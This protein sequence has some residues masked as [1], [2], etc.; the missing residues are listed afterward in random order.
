MAAVMLHGLRPTRK[1]VERVEELESR[2]NRGTRRGAW[3]AVKNHCDKGRGWISN[4]TS[5]IKYP[6]P[7]RNWRFCRECARSYGAALS[8]RWSRVTELHAFVV[9]TTGWDWRDDRNRRAMMAAWRRLYERLVR[10]FGYRPKLLHFKEHAGPNG[11][12][13][14]NVVWSWPY[15]DKRELFGPG[16]LTE[17]CGLGFVGRI[18]KIGDR[19]LMLTRKRPGDALVR[20]SRKNSF[21]VVCYA[22]KTGSRT[23]GARDGDDWPRHTRRWSASRAASLEMGH[24]EHNPEWEYTVNEPFFDE[25]VSKINYVLLPE[26]YLP[27]RESISLIPRAPPLVSWA[28][29]SSSPVQLSWDLQTPWFGIP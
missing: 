4:K 7:C 6:A 27:E 19:H 29:R 1:D 10:R 8:I 15:I 26:R 28:G 2:S 20:Y 12:L 18:L 3:S 13:H 14:L 23:A 25:P 24:R 5:R 17:Q 22:R 16:G 21:R 9:L 11:L